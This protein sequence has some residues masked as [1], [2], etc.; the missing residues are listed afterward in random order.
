MFP[1]ADNAPYQLC[2]NDVLV[3]VALLQCVCQQLAVLSVRYLRVAS[4]FALHDLD[5]LEHILANPLQLLLHVQMLK[6]SN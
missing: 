5:C 1:S 2:P 4:H 6:S 3:Y